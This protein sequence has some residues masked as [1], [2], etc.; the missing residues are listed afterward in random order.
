[1]IKAEAPC[2]GHTELFEPYMNPGESIPLRGLRLSLAM[3]V[4]KVCPLQKE[5]R[6]LA[7]QQ[8]CVRGLW[9]AKVYTALEGKDEPSDS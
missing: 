7:D 4:C 9:G 3:E 6:N 1:M 5:C 8:H 2:E